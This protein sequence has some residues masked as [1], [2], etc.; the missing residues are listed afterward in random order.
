MNDFPARKRAA[1][2][3]EGGL[4]D[5]L[6]GMRVLSFIHA[7][8]P[9]HEIVIYSDCGG[10]STQ[11]T[12]AGMSPYV[13]TVVPIH[14]TG[15][16]K[17]LSE[18]GRLDNLDAADLTEMRASDLF[19]DAHGVTMFVPAA[20]LLN[21]PVFDILRHRPELS[22]PPA[23][24]KEADQLLAPYGDAIFV[25]LNLMKYGGVVLQYYEPRIRHLLMGLLEHPRVVMFDLLT[26]QYDFAHWPQPE[27]AVREQATREESA[28]C[29][30]LCGLSD[31]IV[32]LVDLPIATIA[33][34][35]QRCH[36]FVGVDNGMKHLAWA[37]D[38]PRTYFAPAR[39]ETDKALRWM[40]DLHRLL[41]FDC[42][43]HA[44]ECHLDE[45]R[46]LLMR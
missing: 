2:R 17:R 41:T 21:V 37:L 24:L 1:V 43:V 28:F 13:S 27:R 34:L 23:S 29:R 8:R 32:P 35:L 19:V 14:Q 42:P 18:M 12:I 22:L 20:A 38:I 11:L 5:H 31:R 25:G 3:L 44:L 9:C 16:P 6:L 7:R 40:P 45:A 46:T 33:A 4:G 39:F 10:A 26:S 15:P 36:Y 30:A